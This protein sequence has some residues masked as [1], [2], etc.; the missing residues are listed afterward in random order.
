MSEMA[1]VVVNGTSCVSKTTFAQA[2]AQIMNFRHVEL[3]ALRWQPNWIPKLM[4]HETLT[5]PS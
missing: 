1:S 2:L 5:Q 4:S 3:D